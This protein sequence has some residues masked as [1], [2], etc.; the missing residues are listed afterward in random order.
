MSFTPSKS[1]FDKIKKITEVFL[2]RKFIVWFVLATVLTYQSY[3]LLPIEQQI[4]VVKNITQT[5]VKNWDRN[6]SIGIAFFFITLV[7]SYIM[8]NFGKLETCKI[9][10]FLSDITKDILNGTFVVAATLFG[11]AM[12]FLARHSETM[13]Q[14]GVTASFAIL[15]SLMTFGIAFI[16]YLSNIEQMTYMFEHLNKSLYRRFHTKKK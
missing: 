8:F 1:S 12:V 7:V 9:T 15:F 5:V 10:M 6:G 3:A 16:I 14:Y 2:V 11:M 4:A 13:Y